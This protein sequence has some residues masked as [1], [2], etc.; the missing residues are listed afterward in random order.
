MGSIVS[1]NLFDADVLIENWKVISF[2]ILLIL[3]TIVSSHTADEKVYEISKLQKEVRELKSE[4][5]DVRTQLM[6][7]RMGSNLQEKVKNIGL[8]SSTT[9]PQV[10]TVKKD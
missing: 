3:M 5:V 2:S 6:N 7:S 10:I 8:E 4:F 9:P 1:G